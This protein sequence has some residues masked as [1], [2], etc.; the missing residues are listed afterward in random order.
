M[1]Q[2]KCDRETLIYQRTI[3]P[4]ID[5]KSREIKKIIKKISHE[6]EKFHKIFENFARRKWNIAP[7]KKFTYAW[8]LS[9]IAI[10]YANPPFLAYK[11]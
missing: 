5:F 1:C 8:R 6:K 4:Q 10:I 2:E 9:K 7:K 11:S 3:N